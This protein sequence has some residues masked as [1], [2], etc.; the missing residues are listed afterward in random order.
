MHQ[1]A[2]TGLDRTK[3]V[4]WLAVFGILLAILT[5]PILESFT[6][7]P[8]WSPTPSGITIYL[9]LRYIYEKAAWRWT[10]PIPDMQGTWRGAILSNH[11]EVG[12]KEVVVTIR[13]TFSRILVTFETE[14]STSRSTMALIS[15]RE[16]AQELRYEYEVQ[17]GSFPG[18]H[19]GVGKYSF[20]VDGDDLTLEGYYYTDGTT[21]SPDAHSGRVELRQVSQD[22]HSYVSWRKLN[23]DDGLPERQYPLIR[24][25]EEQALPSPS[26]SEEIVIDADS[27]TVERPHTPTVAKDDHL[28]DETQG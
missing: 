4:I 13:Q 8:S 20:E 9:V 10:S 7:L 18:P 26:G 28:A 2:L 27:G 3:F 15:V 12:T 24:P 17:H 25:Q 23:P 5:A 1:Y 19:R 21:G 16:G 11:S 6:R 14:L 22:I